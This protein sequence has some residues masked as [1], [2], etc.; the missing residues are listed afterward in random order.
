MER[1]QKTHDDRMDR[2]END[3]EAKHIDITEKI[4]NKFKD[5][6]KIIK[7][8]KRNTTRTT[9]EVEDLKAIIQQ[10]QTTL[11]TLQATIDKN[12]ASASKGIKEVLLLANNVEALDHSPIWV[13]RARYCTREHTGLKDP[14]PRLH[15]KYSRDCQRIS[16]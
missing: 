14:N 3:M 16:N 1:A 13:K 4:E 8:T 15:R 11:D 6:D 2:L 10:Q 12:E 5:L 7:T 9:K